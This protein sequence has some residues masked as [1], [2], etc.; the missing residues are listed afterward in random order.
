MVHLGNSAGTLATLAG[1]VLRNHGIT[2]LTYAIFKVPARER[3]G[4]FARLAE[5]AAAGE[6]AVDYRETGLEA[7]PAIWA[8]FTAG[9]A[10]TKIIVKPNETAP[11]WPPQRPVPYTGRR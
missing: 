7:L 8:D 4:A 2:I 3:S 11:S 1:P 5:H 10:Q 6:L 9:K